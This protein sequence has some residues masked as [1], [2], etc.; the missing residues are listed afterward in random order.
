MNSDFSERIIIKSI[1][2][3][4]E[5]TN[6]EGLTT[7]KLISIDDTRIVQQNPAKYNCTLYKGTNFNLSFIYKN[8]TTQQPYDLTGFVVEGKAFLINNK[9]IKFDLHPVIVNHLKGKIIIS[10]TPDETNEIFVDTCTT[11]YHYYINLISDTGY[12]YRI[13]IGNIQ[14]CQ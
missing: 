7:M 13:L 10:L 1:L 8:S 3:P 4:N 9:D 6:Y 2:T 14:V 5:C 11:F 12:T